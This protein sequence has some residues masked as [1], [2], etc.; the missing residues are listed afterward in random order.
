MSTTSTCCATSIVAWN[1]FDEDGER[2]Q[3]VA[4]S[5]EKMQYF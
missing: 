1:Y 5:G 2:L 4:A 3:D